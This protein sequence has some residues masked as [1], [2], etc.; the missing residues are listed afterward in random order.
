[1]KRVLTF[2]LAILMV[3]VV[4]FGCSAHNDMAREPD[5]KMPS[6]QESQAGAKENEADGIGPPSGESKGCFATFVER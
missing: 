1:M 4:L 6:N 2:T 5:T 3:V